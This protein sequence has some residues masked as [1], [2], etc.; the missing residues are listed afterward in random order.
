[1]SASGVLIKSGI[2]PD[3][4]VS[5]KIVFALHGQSRPFKLNGIV[6]R[7]DSGG[8]GIHFTDMTPYAR[9]H[10]NDLLKGL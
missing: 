4:G 10:L 7:T 8:I 1:M 5:A 6:V 2:K 9:K 3:V